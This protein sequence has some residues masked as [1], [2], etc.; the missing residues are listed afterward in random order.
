MNCL[1]CLLGAR[2]HAIKSMVTAFK[3][4]KKYLDTCSLKGLNILHCFV[5]KRFGC[6]HKSASGRKPCKISG[7]GCRCIGWHVRGALEITQIGFPAQF[8][9]FGIPDRGVVTAGR[10][11]CHSIIDHGV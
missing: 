2:C 6:A 3:L 4:P 10:G 5:K 11:V 1:F 9:G 8:I 7:S